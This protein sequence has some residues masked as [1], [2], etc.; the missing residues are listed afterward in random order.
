MAICLHKLIS[1]VLPLRYVVAGL[2]ALSLFT[3][4]GM[5]AGA[6]EAALPDSP[7]AVQAQQNGSPVSSA[8]QTDDQKEAQIRAELKGQ[9]SKRILG[10]LP[11]FRSVSVD[12]KFVPLTPG[13]KLKLSLKNSFD[14]SSFLASGM[15]S[16]ISQWRDSY[17]EFGQGAAGYGRRYWHSF[18]DQALASTTTV[19]LVPVLTHEDPRYFTLGHGTFRERSRYAITRIFITR[20]DSGKNTA[21]ISEMGGR[22]LYAGLSVLYYPA[23]YQTASEAAQRFGLTVGFDAGANLAKEFW[24]DLRAWIIGEIRAKK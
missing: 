21:N 3:A 15:A 17:P 12:D 9:Q 19:F 13:E 8:A 7:G 11:N 23:H 4:C 18:T 6:Q 24:P 2:T 10:I 14:Y 1:T 16:G 22:A 5:C 20:S